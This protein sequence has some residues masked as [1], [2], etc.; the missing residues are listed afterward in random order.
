MTGNVA[1]WKYKTLAEVQ[2]LP[3]SALI[4][5]WK[6]LTES[7]RLFHQNR[8]PWTD[9]MFWMFVTLSSVMAERAEQ[10]YNDYEKDLFKRRKP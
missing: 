5:D 4:A 6:D 3:T 9:E 1:S 8:M 10:A 2:A 7:I